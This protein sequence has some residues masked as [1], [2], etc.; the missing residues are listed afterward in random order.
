MEPTKRLAHLRNELL[1]ATEDVDRALLYDAISNEL[2]RNQKPSEALAAST[3]G[4]E[5]LER[6]AAHDTDKLPSLAMSL[7]NLGG[8]LSALQRYNESIVAYARSF[9]IFMNIGTSNLNLRQLYRL[10]YIAERIGIFLQHIF[11]YPRLAAKF[12]G[13]AFAFVDT[14]AENDSNYNRRSDSQAEVLLRSLSGNSMLTESKSSLSEVELESL[15]RLGVA[16]FRAADYLNKWAQETFDYGDLPKALHIARSTLTYCELFSEWRV[17]ESWASIHR[18]NIKRVAE[19]SRVAGEIGPRH[20]QMSAEGDRRLWSCTGE[21]LTLLVE[22]LLHNGFESSN[23]YTLADGFR[24]TRLYPVRD[25]EY[26]SS[27]RQPD[28]F[29]TYTWSDNYVDLQEAIRSGLDFIGTLIREARPELDEHVIERLVGKTL[30]IWI[31]F[32]FIDQ[33][34]RNLGQE[35]REVLP[36]LMSQADIHFVL[37]DESLT[38]AWC[39][40]ELALFNQ[41]FTTRQPIEGG[42]ILSFIAPSKTRR[43]ETFSD[44]KVSNPEDKQEIERAILELFPGGMSGFDYLLIQASSMS[45]PFVVSGHFAQSDAAM[46]RVGKLVDKWLSI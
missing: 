20:S 14:L 37:S 27:P 17:N 34:A 32:I 44:T 35:V 46:A 39:C 4:I 25:F 29:V 36:A 16:T 21:Q 7:T 2:A 24:A 45:D 6:L 30:G 41:P 12:L 8:H 5:I 23:V 19:W 3:R 22:D 28:I 43:Y 9:E 1:N 31:D 15:E 13:L 38:R 18:T 40:Y 11:G 26:H 33:S 42:S 10:G